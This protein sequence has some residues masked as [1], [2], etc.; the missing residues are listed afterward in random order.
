[1][2]A[3]AS[4]PS[5]LIV[6]AGPVGLALGLGLARQGVPSLVLEREHAT[7]EH[8][9]APGIHIRTREVLR[10]WGIDD[11]FTSRGHLLRRAVLH[12]AG[13]APL[14][15]ADFGVLAD[16]AAD[17]GLL[18]LEQSVTEEL[19]LDAATET[20]LC[21]V[22]FGAEVTAVE[23]EGE[24]VTVTV[25]GAEGEQRLRA[26]FVVGC[27][28]ASSTVREQMGMGF[29]GHTYPMRPMLADVRVDDERDSLAW[30]RTCI[31]R[32]GMTSALRLSAGVWRIIGLH[33]GDRHEEALGDE[34]V[35]SRAARVLGPG[36]TEV[37]WSSRF[38]IHRRAAPRFRVGRVLMAGDSAHV[39]SPVGGMGMNSGIHDAHNLAWKLAHVLRGGDQERLLDSYDVE[40]REVVVETVSRNTDLATRAFLQSPRPVRLAAFAV[41]RR[42][43][44][45][46]RL[47]RRALRGASMIDLRYSSSPVLRGGGAVGMRLPNP[48]LE[49]QG[50]PGARLHDAIPYRPVVV[51]LGETPP[52]AGLGITVIAVDRTRHPE[53]HRVLSGVLGAREGWLLV[54]PDQHIAWTGRADA[55][56]LRAAVRHA[57]GTPVSGCD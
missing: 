52:P 30:P 22:R 38:R 45:W 55:A 57:L 8:S 6:G 28:G 3:S 13:A 42:A 14:I 46:P 15:S 47:A 27:D 29:T 18:V 11:R 26:P 10:Q 33:P 44:A 12:R 4:S 36:S 21:E 31:D 49:G 50:T 41:A 20:G 34:E 53:A 32:R 2:A 24:A 1:M 39:H 48:P 25:S 5:V 51:Q 35:Q 54:R 37:V 43:L 9:K 17:P 56:V 19:L 40:R 7:S 16:E 23:D